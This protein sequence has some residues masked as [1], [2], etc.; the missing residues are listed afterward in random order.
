MVQS[1]AKTVAQYLAELPPDRRKEIAKVRKAVKQHLPR[2]Y[3]ETMNC[4]MISYE[5][6]LSRYP[7]TYN[8]KPLAFAGLAAQKNN[9][10]LYVLCVYS[11]PKQ[12]TAL[13]AAFKKAGK[14]LRMGKCCIHFKKADDLPL[15]A[16]GEILAGVTPEKFVAV[17]ESS[18]KR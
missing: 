16:I 13:K 15:E 2:G 6:P 14:K 12:L 17:Y 11:D 5:I 8:G 1:R 10:T 7:E 9:N 18:R 4:G 3:R